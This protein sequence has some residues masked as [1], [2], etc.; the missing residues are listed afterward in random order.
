MDNL[1]LLQTHTVHHSG[2]TLR[3]EQ[4]HQVVLHRHK[5]LRRTGVT[6]TSRTTTQLTVNTTR[7]V[8][9]GT[10]N[11]QTTR[12]L[13]LVAELDVG[14]TTR[15][16]GSDGN[17]T[18]TTSLG[19]DLS[20]LLV[21]FSIQHVVFDTAQFKHTAQQLR[22]LDRSSTNQ[23]GTAL[24]HKA[25]NLLDYGVIFLAFGLVN[26]II[27]VI[28]SNWAVGGNA[29]HVEFVDVPKLA[30]LGLGSTG[31]TT[32]F[33][34]HTEV[35]LQSD[36]CKGLSCSLNLNVLLG[37]D[38]LVQTI[39]VAAAIQNTA[40][41]LIDN[42]H[43]VVHNHI[44]NVL[45]KHTERFEQLVNGV[46]ALAL[47]SVLAD[48]LVLLD[49]FLFGGQLALFEVSNGRADVGQHEESI[50][51]K[52]V[53]QEVVTL[54]GQLHRIEFLVDNEIEV[55]DNLGQTAVVILD[56]E[57]FGLLHQSLDTCLAEEL[58]ERFVLGQTLVCTVQQHATLLHI[59]RSDEFARLRHQRSHQS[60][61]CAV[62]LLDGTT[63]LL[64]HLVVALGH[65]TRNNQRGTS[66]VNQHRVHLIDNRK[67]VF[68]L[69]HIV[70]RD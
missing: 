56:I 38:S 9:L 55:I 44:L 36:G 51:T 23:H 2:D 21:L 53:R 27:T 45:L 15:H 18:R 1:A 59:A 28:T 67:V 42:L 10:Q 16:I 69:Y 37:L 39:R 3:A 58:D 57:V 35:V 30:C 19:N 64:K 52:D 70:G 6:L 49:C 43:F 4:T 20:L 29:H 61:L 32:K 41:L 8:A 24:S 5:E 46:N 65:G 50:L 62:N 33:V 12:S 60:L 63:I 34:V 14:T 66:V 68:A 47:N 22:N 11:C 48:N 17:L 26:Q 25:V 13:N 54:V 31:H 7:L 40:S